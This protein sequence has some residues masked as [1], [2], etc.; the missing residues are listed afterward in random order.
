MM[1]RIHQNC[2]G[3]ATG[4]PG[5]VT[6]MPNALSDR[7][8]HEDG[9]DYGQHFH[10]LIQAMRLRGDVGVEQPRHP[11]LA[12]DTVGQSHQMIVHVPKAVTERV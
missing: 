10:H 11:I 7:E 8:R 5:R 6:F 1:P 4:K 9:G 2:S 12:K 3:L